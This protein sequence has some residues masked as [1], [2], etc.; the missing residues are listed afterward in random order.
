M[1]GFSTYRVDSEPSVR[2]LNSVCGFSAS[3]ADFRQVVRI[4]HSPKPSVNGHFRAKNRRF[5]AHPA[6]KPHNESTQVLKNPHDQSKIRTGL[7]ES[8]RPVQ[9]PHGSFSYVM[10]RTWSLHAS[11]KR[12]EADGHPLPQLRDTGVSPGW[13]RP[14]Q[15]PYRH[16]KSQIVG[17]PPF[18]NPTKETGHDGAHPLPAPTP[19]YGPIP[20]LGQEGDADHS[21]IRIANRLKTAVSE[22]CGKSE[23]RHRTT[24]FR[25]TF[26][27]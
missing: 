18:L 23:A 8:T 7:Q 27:L 22:S 21:D 15:G 6:G 2:I 5:R 19:R 10:D 14:R 24:S 20:R 3:R 12:F 9:N 4:A 11:R 26:G 17:I 13:G 16:S 25:H 1:C